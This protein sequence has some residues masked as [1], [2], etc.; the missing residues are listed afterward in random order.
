MGGNPYTIGPNQDV[1]WG[2]CF[3]KQTNPKHKIKKHL[4][5]CRREIF[6]DVVSKRLFRIFLPEP[7]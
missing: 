4:P 5:T 2:F 1:S 3:G 7:F 6:L